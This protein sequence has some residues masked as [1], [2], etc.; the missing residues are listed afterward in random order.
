MPHRHVNVYAGQS[1]I[2]AKDRSLTA[3]DEDLNKSSSLRFSALCF[4]FLWVTYSRHAVQRERRWNQNTSWIGSYIMSLTKRNDTRHIWIKT[5]KSTFLFKYFNIY[6]TF[7]NTHYIT[8]VLRCRKIFSDCFFRLLLS[9][10]KTFCIATFLDCVEVVYCASHRSPSW[11]S[12][13]H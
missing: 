10:N 13:G 2:Q 11:V 12:W 1:F 9:S 6:N 8:Q 7:Y 3:P 4:P 5:C